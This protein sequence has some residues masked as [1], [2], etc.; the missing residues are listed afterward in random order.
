MRSRT[1]KRASRST[2]S[3][4]TP[5]PTPSPLDVAARILTR[6][7]RSEADLHARLVARGY[8]QSTATR[9]VDRC[10]E[11]GYVGDE[12]LADERARALR[13]RGAGSLKIA[14]DLEG[15]GL[16]EA[17]IARAIE[18]SRDGEA[19]AVWARRALERQGRPRGAKAWRLLASR[20]FPEE[21][22]RDVLGEPGE[23]PR[24]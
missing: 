3:D 20:G 5:R 11:L 18:E 6:A 16:S 4:R 15:R 12:R 22:V 24:D 23:D 14:S 19:E 8:Q 13:A 2:G 9:T 10:R 1:P 21:V 7:P 17:I